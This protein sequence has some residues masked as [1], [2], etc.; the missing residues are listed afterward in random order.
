MGMMSDLVHPVTGPQ[1]V[2]GP[3]VRMSKS[4]PA[5]QRH[6]PVFGADTSEVLLEAGIGA[7]EIAALLADGTIL[8][9]A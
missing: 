4:P 2:V 3:V 7:D 9:P 5:A 1:R 8:G 6:A